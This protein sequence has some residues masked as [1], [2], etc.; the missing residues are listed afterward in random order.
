MI[1][2]VVVFTHN[3]NVNL[4]TCKLH[5]SGQR[6]FLTSLTAVHCTPGVEQDIEN[7]GSKTVGARKNFLQLPSTNLVCA[8]H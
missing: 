7:W 1:S 2:D 8:P 5:G 4:F 3:V 6:P